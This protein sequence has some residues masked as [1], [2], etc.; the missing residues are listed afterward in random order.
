MSRELTPWG[1][2]VTSN[3][4][5]YTCMAKGE[6]IYFRII[7]TFD[8]TWSLSAKTPV[9]HG[10]KPR[11]ATAFIKKDLRGEI[12]QIFRPATKLAMEFDPFNAEWFVRAGGIG[13]GY[14]QL[15]S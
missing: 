10:K 5:M 14:K 13:S 2:I 3:V 7:K 12:V 1:E 8:G 4:T 9:E 15:K 11:M 6:K